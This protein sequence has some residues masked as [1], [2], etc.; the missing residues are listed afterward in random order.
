MSRKHKGKKRKHKGKKHKSDGEFEDD[1]TT[2]DTY[3][4]KMGWGKGKGGYMEDLTGVSGAYADDGVT[5]YGGSFDSDRHKPTEI[6]KGDNYSIWIGSEEKCEKEVHKFNIV[7]NCTG[8]SLF[9]PSNHVLP[10]ELEQ[11]VEQDTPNDT[12]EYLLDWD[13]YSDINLKAEFWGAFTD[14]LEGRK[15]KC[16]IFCTGGHGRTGTA[17]ACLLIAAC[18]YTAMQAIEYLRKEYCHKAVE[19]KTQTE[20]VRKVG[21][22]YHPESQKAE[23]KEWDDWLKKQEEEENKIKVKELIRNGKEKGKQA[24][25]CPYCGIYLPHSKSEADACMLV[26]EELGIKGI[27]P[28]TRP[29]NERHKSY[30][31]K[32]GL[33]AV[34]KVSV[35]Y[36]PSSASCS[37]GDFVDC[38]P[39]RE[40][41]HRVHRS[42]A[43]FC[44]S[45]GH[46]YCHGHTA[47]GK[48]NAPITTCR[49][50]YDGTGQIT[51]KWS[52]ED[53]YVV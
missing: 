32:K 24:D 42:K 53:D 23:D 43:R 21:R 36:S 46:W 22:H 15:A 6:I 25:H 3:M 49:F 52:S 18:D 27:K 31:G 37:T 29:Y 35:S 5:V 1:Y 50:G 8:R 51:P 44:T 26:M 47:I 17:T 28:D 14:Y 10:K 16:L 19:S 4:S 48:H 13:D 33:E 12:E 9:E 7:L 30:E 2:Y 41:S 34:E 39:Y 11:F 20:Y 38:T 40:P 45:C